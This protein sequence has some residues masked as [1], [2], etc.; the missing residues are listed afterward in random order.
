MAH[1]RKDLSMRNPDR[2]N[3]F[4]L[5]GG[6]FAWAADAPNVER[7]A[8][9]RGPGSRRGGGGRRTPGLL[10]PLATMSGHRGP[11]RHGGGFGPPF[12]PGFGPPFGGRGPRARRGDIRL[13][14]LRL[15]AEQPMHGYQIIQELGSR[16]GG[17]WNPSPGSV[18]PTL[19]ALEDQGLVRA[20]DADGKRVFRLTDAGRDRLAEEADRPAPWD[21]A[22]ASGGG[23][24][25]LRDV[26]VG[27]A[28]AARQVAAAGTRGQVE[29]AV[30][31]L[32]ETRRRLY[33]LL[34]EDP[35]DEPEGGARPPEPRR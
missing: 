1:E 10:P 23:H 32:R 21:E 27:V 31:L 30:A 6:R 33:Q 20:E 4:D 17:A 5:H 29:R 7:P 18:Y 26:T 15:L 24:R 22:A 2:L 8:R 16:S 9:R 35:D 12:G 14:V 3:P 19:A 34:A 13:A 28:D 25:E 11:G